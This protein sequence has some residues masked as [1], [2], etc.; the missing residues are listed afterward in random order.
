MHH[1]TRAHALARSRMGRYTRPAAQYMGHGPIGLTAC[2]RTIARP[3]A[4]APPHVYRSHHATHLRRTR[5]HTLARHLTFTNTSPFALNRI[6]RLRYC[7]T[8]HRTCGMPHHTR[9]AH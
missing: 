3:L 8:S 9:A 2:H 6:A 5:S 4:T 1:A 7:T